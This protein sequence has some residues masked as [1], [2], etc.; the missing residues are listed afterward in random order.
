MI[1]RP[2][3]AVHAPLGFR[4]V[5]RAA[6]APVGGKGTETGSTSTGSPPG[7]SSPQR[8]AWREVEERRAGL[9]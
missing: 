5:L 3:L 9:A 4:V 6:L 1:I 8:E 7:F 2:Y